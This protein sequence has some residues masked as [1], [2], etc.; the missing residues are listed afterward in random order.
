MN[1]L[2]LL[3]RITKQPQL[4]ISKGGQA[5]TTI[6]LAVDDRGNEKKPVDFID[7]KAFGKTADILCK[8]TDKGQCLYI[9]AKVKQNVYEKEDGNKT[10]SIDFILQEFE[11]IG[12]TPKAE[13]K[14][15]EDE[16]EDEEETPNESNENNLPW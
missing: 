9:E 13:N 4:Q 2:Q 7:I 5:Y 1:K 11:F 16:E 12:S 10:Y 15:E 6:T 8:F 14:E 3:G